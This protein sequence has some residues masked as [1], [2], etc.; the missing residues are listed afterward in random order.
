VYWGTTEEVKKRFDAAGV[1]I[2][3][4]KRDVHLHQVS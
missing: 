4:P 3:F 1:S 2:P